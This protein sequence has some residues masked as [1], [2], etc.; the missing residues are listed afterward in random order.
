MKELD[1]GDNITEFGVQSLSMCRGQSAIASEIYIGATTVVQ[2]RA[3]SGLGTEAL[4]VDSANTLYYSEDGVLYNKEK[5][6]LIQYPCYKQGSASM[7]ESITGFG[8]A[9]FAYAVKVTGEIIIPS[10]VT[11]IGDIFVGC[12]M[13]SLVIPDGVTVFSTNCFSECSNLETFN[14]PSNLV[15]INES[16]FEGCTSLKMPIIL[17][18][19]VTTIGQNA[20]KDCKGI[21]NVVIGNGVSSLGTKVFYGCTNLQSVTLGSGVLS[22]GT[23]TFRGCTSLTSVIWNNSLQV[24][25]QQLVHIAFTNVKA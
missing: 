20:F 5:T 17:P 18:N 13:S 1:V 6:T 16:A 15:T 23:E 14:M 24:Q 9:A 2:E 10:Q 12:S 25:L 3:F 21:T 4:V 7:L 8:P 22:I 19:S 11:E